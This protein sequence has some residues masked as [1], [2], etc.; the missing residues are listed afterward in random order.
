MDIRKNR[1]IRAW[2]FVPVWV[3]ASVAVTFVTLAGAWSWDQYRR[4]NR[5]RGATYRIGVD[6]N[7]PNNYW[8]EQ[9]GATGFDVDVLN[10]AARR[11]GVKLDWV[12]SPRG[13]RAALLEGSVDLWPVGYYRPG[14]LPGVHQTRPWNE[15]QHVWIWDRARMPA[16][17]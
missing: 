15:I 17:P 1:A 9:K 14:E 5:Y 11:A 12:F 8:S 3:R 16:R 2:R 13:S 6:H 7:P 10:D 4:A